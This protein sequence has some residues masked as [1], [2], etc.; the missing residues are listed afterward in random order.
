MKPQPK[1]KPVRDPKYLA[2][3]RT[4]DCLDC[5]WPAELKGIEA[6]HIETGGTATKC[7]DDLTV[8][9]CTFPPYGR[10]C[11]SKADKSP[12]SAEKYRPIAEKLYREWRHK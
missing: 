10:G 12:E 2:Y 4:M 3:I 7:G 11:H 6:H 9:L 5:G 1:L 8:P